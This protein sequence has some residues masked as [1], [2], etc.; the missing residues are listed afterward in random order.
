MLKP[1]LVMDEPSIKN[2]KVVPGEELLDL[3]GVT[4]MLKGTPLKVGE[5]EADLVVVPLTGNVPHSMIVLVPLM[6]V[7]KKVDPWMLEEGVI[8]PVS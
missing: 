2:T 6:L 3:K 4:W 8:L 5:K 7:G 1:L